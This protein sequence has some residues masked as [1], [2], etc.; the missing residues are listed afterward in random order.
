[1][2]SERTHVAV[3][4]VDASIRALGPNHP[5]AMVLHLG[6]ADYST[7]LIGNLPET[8]FRLSVQ[9][10]S[11]LLIDDLTSVT[12][13]GSKRAPAMSRLSRTAAGIWKVCDAS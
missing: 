7:T 9:A 4:V 12:E 1:M 11:L 3:R 10:L 2:P 13:V 6:E 8:S 5:G